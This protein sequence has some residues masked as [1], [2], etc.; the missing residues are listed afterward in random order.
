MSMNRPQV[1]D[2]SPRSSACADLKT[3]HVSAFAARRRA[4]QNAQSDAPDHRQN[5]LQVA[6]EESSNLSAAKK[7]KNA[8]VPTGEAL[9]SQKSKVRKIKE[10]SKQHPGGQK[11]RLKNGSRPAKAGQRESAIAAPE[12]TLNT[13]PWTIE[14]PAL[15][16]AATFD[17]GENEKQTR[18]G[19]NAL[20]SERPLAK[21]RDLLLEGEEEESSEAEIQSDPESLNFHQPVQ[22][23][24]STPMHANGQL[25]PHVPI[26]DCVIERTDT[27]WTISLEEG[28]ILT[29]AGQY[30]I[31]VRKGA[32]SILGAILHQSSMT[33]RIHAPLTHSLPSIRTLRNPF[34]SATQRTI[35]TVSNCSN[36][37]RLLRQ[38]SPKFSH[39]WSRRSL[40]SAEDVPAANLPKWTFQ[41]L[42]QSSGDA[43]NPP[44]RV[45]ELPIDWK[46]SI[47]ALASQSHIGLPNAMLVCGPK[48]SGKS[49]LS[50][51]LMNAIL[52]NT[53][54]ASQAGNTSTDATCIALLD[55]DPGQPE[56]SP[57]G[58]ISLVQIKTCNFGP[59]FTHPIA[60]D[61]GCGLIRSHHIGSISPN[62]DPQHYLRCVL[63]LF[64]HYRQMLV[65]YPTCPLIVN[66]AGWI[67]GT[68]LELLLGCI[69]N[70]S[71]T[72]VIYTSTQGPSEVVETISKATLEAK[73]QLQL[74]S[75]QPAEVA[76]RS[77]TDLRMMQTMSYFHLDEPE[78]GNLHWNAEPFSEM[79]PL[80]VHF[81]GP[82]QA[83]YGVLLQG[84]EFD[85]EYLG[86][87]L[88][89]CIV[90]VVVVEDDTAL[91]SV[92]GAQALDAESDAGEFEDDKPEDNA[93]SRSGSGHSDSMS[94][95]AS[96]NIT[97]SP[98]QERNPNTPSNYNHHPPLPR[99][100][101]LI[102]YI[103][104][105]HHLTPPLPPTHT[106]CLG[107]AII[108]SISA[109]AQTLN[110]VTPIPASILNTLHRHQRKIVLVR[111]SLETPTWAYKEDLYMQMSRR[112]R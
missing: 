17:E 86:Q 73:V 99:T 11:R 95:D 15:I 67:Q 16:P 60:S 49:T 32:V 105:I 40:E 26:K 66:T 64:H 7:R 63:D 111:G 71:L 23:N 51:I 52:T 28:D 42:E 14:N 98:Q 48:G 59:P 112:K 3:G 93:L 87:V 33:Y 4:A 102:P 109:E 34:A 27:A 25:F 18:D 9:Q 5:V 89:G 47:A 100:S 97:P 50:R 19:D 36:G 41:Y 44:S 90:G 54:M 57:P 43:C 29:L 55:V 58:Q 74:L 104:S 91:A 81:A 68:G 85:P 88:E 21:S 108:H 39:L 94:V 92:P 103:P 96:A 77:P 24:S 53:S 110:L 65:Q 106:H 8:S 72:N 76:A 35:I 31:W 69:R 83:F 82:N 6:A 12:E 78:K 45:L 70:M 79:A 101:S 62:D 75:S 22:D 61:D 84:Q 80:S 1:I 2:F 107:Q 10:L 38:L 56:F 13:S 20:H 30:E 46:T 37:L